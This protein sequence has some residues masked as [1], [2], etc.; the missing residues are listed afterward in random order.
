MKLYKEYGSEQ[1]SVF[2]DSQ[3]IMNL[4]PTQALELLRHADVLLYGISRA[5]ELIRRRG[6][7]P[8]ERE[9]LEKSGAVAEVDA[10]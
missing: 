8:S 4:R 3:A 9:Q 5:Q 2:G 7:S 6:L 10:V 1:L